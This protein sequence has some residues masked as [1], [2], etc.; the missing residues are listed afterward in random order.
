MSDHS[1]SRA[2]TRQELLRLGQG[3]EP[4]RFV[5]LAARALAQ[6]PEDAGVR[7]LLAASLARLGL[8]TLALD[9]LGR[10]RAAGADAPEIAQLCAA[11]EALP[12]DRLDAE[13]WIDRARAN[14]EALGDRGE[15]LSRCLEQWQERTRAA[16]LCCALDG[17]VV[18]RP[19][20]GDEP[21]AWLGLRDAAGEARAFAALDLP[22]IRE[23]REPVL[24]EGLAGPWIL[25]DLLEALRRDALGHVPRVTVLEGDAMRALDALA[26]QDMR[27]PLGE[28]RVLVFAGEGALQRLEGW[29]EVRLDRRL[30]GARVCGAEADGEV[31]AMLGRVA[32]LQQEVQQQLGAACERLYADRDAAWW[33]RRLREAHSG[34]GPPL[35]IVVHT[36]RYST[37]LRHAAA[38]LVD[39]LERCGHEAD[40]L[41]EPDESSHL[42]SLATLQRVL[43]VGADLMVVLNHPRG[44]VGTNAVPAGLPLVCWVQDAMPHLYDPRIGRRQGPLDL[45]AGAIDERMLLCAGF[46][47]RKAMRIPVVA[48]AAKFH[49]GP[50]EPRLSRR[51]A[52]DLACATHQSETPRA[53]HERLLAGSD[54]TVRP[55]LEE[56]RPDIE[57]LV[58]RAHE[59]NLHFELREAVHRCALAAFG[60]RG[61][62]IVQPVCTGYALPLADRIFRHQ[63]LEWA[64]EACR[65]R[66]WRL[67]LFGRGWE[68]HPTLAEF[69]RGELAH[70]EELRASY[71]VAAAHLHLCTSTLAH[72]RVMEC[73]LSGGVSLCRLSRDALSARRARAQRAALRRGLPHRVQRARLLREGRTTEIDLRLYDAADDPHALRHLRE[74]QVLEI[75]EPRLLEPVG[76]AEFDLHDPRW[77]LLGE[78][79]ALRMLRDPVDPCEENDAL[80]LLGDLAETCFT[81]AAG[82]E[83]LVE[84]AI[85]RP[86][87]RE[88]I[89]RGVRGRVRERLTHDAFARRLLAFAGE[90]YER[91]APEQSQAAGTGKEPRERAA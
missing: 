23:R 67:A 81:D 76:P 75:G 80:W 41:V 2:L 3:G 9:Q 18:I 42:T 53:M 55:L 84:R 25:R 88:S 73:A 15:D 36:S 28:R 43:D 70:G 49:A 71:Q 31:G 45:L 37:Y 90:T 64:A 1:A 69:A 83:R 56:L 66:G 16:T 86:A 57:R 38:D 46:D 22:A 30:R 60:E 68:D 17:N 74:R 87:W 29:M 20:E 5:P 39:A 77:L 54:A 12:D 50:V 52:C 21:A 7:F 48:S 63:A 78:D 58:A 19:R 85:E 82:L 33:A 8:R 40:L 51:L 59:V 62:E 4:W 14:V 11:C 34:D 35:R 24:V 61:R 26:Q 65:R 72:Q 13:D 47:P 91:M 6:H 44:S 27:E 89:G 10:L 79:R 32:R